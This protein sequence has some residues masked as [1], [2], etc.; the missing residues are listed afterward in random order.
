MA[1]EHWRFGRVSLMCREVWPFNFCHHLDMKNAH[2]RKTHR[3][4]V[5]I[6]FL[7]RN[8]FMG[9]LSPVKSATTTADES[10]ETKATKKGDG[11]LGDHV[12]GGQEAVSA[13]IVKAVG[14]TGSG[15]GGQRQPGDG[16]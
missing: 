10:E 8:D 11:W 15:A 3:T 13:H 2:L 12:G 5:G 6:E 14:P 7:E 16:A 1:G 9:N 4:E